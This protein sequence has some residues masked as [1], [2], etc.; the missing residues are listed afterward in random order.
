MTKM[1]KLEVFCSDLEPKLFQGITYLNELWRLDPFDVREIHAEARAKLEEEAERLA[2]KGDSGSG[3]IL[4]LLGEGGSGKTHL[5]RAF[6]NDLH[7]SEEGFVAHMSLSTGLQDYRLYILRKLVDSLSEPYWAPY[8]SQETSLGKLV[9][10]VV[11]L[12]PEGTVERIDEPETRAEALG[13]AVDH[14]LGLPGFQ[15]VDSVLLHVLLHLVV[16]SPVVHNRVYKYLRLEPGLPK[17]FEGTLTGATAIQ[18]TPEEAEKRLV[19][20]AR[21]VRGLPDGRMLAICVDQ[22]EDFFSLNEETRERFRRVG[23]TIRSLAEAMPGT[24]FVVSILE[25]YWKKL[26][27]A[28]TTT[29]LQRFLFDPTPVRLSEA[30]TVEEVRALVGTRLSH[31]WKRAELDAGG[32]DELNL[33]PFSREQIEKL[34]GS[35]AREV[36]LVCSDAR[37]GSRYTRKPPVLREGGEVVKT[38]EII[39]PGLVQISERWND[40]LTTFPTPE[41]EDEAQLAA[42]LADG[43][44]WGLAELGRPSVPVEASQDRVVAGGTPPVTIAL[45]EVTSKFGHLRKRVD[46]VV[47][48]VEPEQPILVRTLPFPSNPKTEIK[49]RLDELVADGAQCLLAS[50]VDLRAIDAMRAFRQQH[51]MD[52]L[53]ESWLER[54]RPMSEVTVISQLLEGMKARQGKPEPGGD[55]GQAAPGAAT[56]EET[57]PGTAPTVE[58]GEGAEIWD[59]AELGPAAGEANEEEDATIPVAPA[60]NPPQPGPVPPTDALEEAPLAEAPIEVGRRRGF[61]L[62]AK[63]G[64]E[65][66]PSYLSRHA[67]FLGAP[68][69][70]KT[71]AAL[72]LVEELALR[73]VPSIL[74]DRKGDLA[75]YALVE[76]YRTEDASA[77]KKKLEVHL[78]T[79]GRPEGRPA[80][81]PILPA[82]VPESGLDE[83][84][85]FAAHAIAA[86][87]NWGPAQ[88]ER[89]AAV[90]LAIQALGQHEPDEP[91]RLAR[92]VEAL[93]DTDIRNLHPEFTKGMEQAEKQLRTALVMKSRLFGSDVELIDPKTLLD[94]G[95]DGRTRLNIISTA[96]LDDA[97]ALFWLSQFMRMLHRHLQ[98]VGASSTKP[99]NGALVLDEADIYIPASNQ[100]KPATKEPLYRGLMQWRA[101]GFG[102]FMATQSPGNLDGKVRDQVSTWF[103]GRIQ[104]ANSLAYLEPIL[105]GS[106]MGAGDVLPGQGTGEFTYR[107]ESGVERIKARPSIVTVKPVPLDTVESLARSGAFLPDQSPG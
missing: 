57:K 77:L 83:E 31:L 75:S 29:S 13:E 99:L 94:D 35:S 40:H 39:P 66:R 15:Q 6:R 93:G 53:F 48:E 107:S 78:F 96:F 84:S 72:R 49:K 30:R 55:A 59:K 32:D 23:D 79:P 62:G 105:E 106:G 97:S 90:K 9:K 28:L 60:A 2:D 33:A 21:L 104:N 16:S 42:L 34:S 11:A 25:N 8:S 63:Q 88:E 20:L 27:E 18:A 86:L 37:E 76:R 4:V 12:L 103:L 64:V 41:V 58:A 7:G 73:G 92:L 52:P 3:R 69:S 5:L 65:V 100:K 51:E 80:A 10:E 1:E 47:Q 85:T 45:C 81:L 26:Q 44:R 102:V 50:A 19:D 17:E 74:I 98:K 38:G 71:T 82:R 67:V 46:A 22:F 14:L 56:V 24:L 43:L 68:G 36:L 87:K 91:V 89:I 61:G 70:G 101:F 54:L 95:Q